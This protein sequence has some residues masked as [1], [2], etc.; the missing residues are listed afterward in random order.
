MF[1]PLLRSALSV[2]S[3]AGHDGKLSIA[4]F[5]R[6]HTEP[7]P[8]FPDEPDRKQFDRICRW[9]T[10]WFTVLPLEDAVLALREQRLPARAL[11]ITFDDGY[12]DNY[13]H[14]LPVLQAYGLSATFFIATGFLDGGRMWNDSIVESIRR[15]QSDTLDLSGLDLDGVG[16]LNLQTMQAR[17]CALELVLK[18]AK[19]LP[20]DKRDAVAAAAGRCAK[21]ELPEDLM[22]STTQLQGMARVGMS[23]G[24][25]TVS[26]PILACLD[27]GSV[28]T[29]LQVSREFLQQCLQRDVKLFAYPNG[30]PGRD[31]LPRDVDLVKAA[32]FE[33]AV[34]T[35]PGANT[36]ESPL[37]E[38]RR[39]SPWDRTRVR[40]GTRLALNLRS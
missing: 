33:A 30:K 36:I 2:L 38:L 31:Y 34:S 28:K 1:D 27:E 3:P 26:H 11:C 4:I 8:L 21:V 24:A 23:I 32:G 19:Y 17:R 9:L 14:A 18:S 12:A 10:S 39:F 40:Y 15:C 13:E 16:V 37:F 20:A 29:E 35:S 6:V 5:H 7:D 25:H 22:M